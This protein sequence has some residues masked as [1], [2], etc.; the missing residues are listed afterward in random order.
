MSQASPIE[1]YQLVKEGYLRYFD[2]AFWLRYPQLREERRR[3]LEAD[4]AVFRDLLVEPVMPYDAGPPLQEVCQ[5]V[6]LPQSVADRLGWMLFGKDGSFPVR[7]HQARALRISLEQDPSLPRHAIVTSGTGSGKTESFLLPIFARL[8]REARQWERPREIHRWWD[9]EHEGTPWKPCRRLNDSARPAALRAIVLYPTNAL[10]EDQISRLRRA[11]ESTSEAPGRPLLFFGRYT[12]ATIGSGARPEHSR[13]DR[14]F[15]AARMLR[16]MEEERDGI[17]ARDVEVLS[18]FP[19]PRLGEML[20][21]WDMI[22]TP[23]DILVTN[24]SMLNVVLMREREDRMFHTT[25]TWLEADTNNALTLVVDELHTYRGT[26]GSEVALLI[27]KLLRRLG[28][29]LDAP[30]LRI[31]GTSA[32]LEG[33]SGCKFIH[34]FFGVPAESFEIVKGSSRPVPTP[35]RLP[36]APFVEIAQAERQ[37]VPDLVRRALTGYDLTGALAAACASGSGAKATP[38]TRIDER[39][40]DERSN[41]DDRALEGLLKA[42]A[43]V[44]PEIHGISFRAHMFCRMIRG[45][46]ACSSPDCTEIEEPY[47]FPERTVGKLYSVPRTRCGCGSR[48]LE[49]LYCYQC[50]EPSLGGFASQPEGG[51]NQWYLS[52]GPSGRSRR[53]QD[54][55]FR[56]PYREYMWYWPGTCPESQPWTHRPSEGERPV[57]FSFASAEYDPRQGLLTLSRRG[58]ATM[59]AV[60]GVPGNDHVRIPALPE[61]CPRCSSEGYNRDPAIFFRGTVR[62]P[63]RAHTT[64]TGVVTQSLV[65]RLIDGLGPDVPSSRI[66]VFTDSRDDA[67]SVAAGLEFNHFRDLIRQLMR[68]EARPTA[69]P[70]ALLDAAARGENIHAEIRE[71]LERLKQEHPDVWVAYR[72]Q[73]RG[74]A[75][76]E[77]LRRIRSFEGRYGGGVA[78]VSWSVLLHRLEKH[79]VRL[80]VNPAGPAPSRACWQ[81]EPWWR[82]YDPPSGEWDPLDPAL[83]QQGRNDRQRHLSAAVANSIF[84]RA[85]RDLESI[86]LGILASAHYQHLPQ[87]LPQAQAEQL[88]SS[89]IRLLGLSELYVGSERQPPQRMPTRLRTYVQ[90]VAEAHGAASAELEREVDECLHA[91]GLVNER[92]QLLLDRAGALFIIKMATAHIEVLRCR[93][94][95]RIH[96]HPSAGVCTNPTCNSRRLQPIRDD[97][98][99]DDY[100]AWLSTKAARRLRVE[101]LTGQTKPLAEQRRRQRYFKGAFLDAP[102]E[103]ALTHALDVLSVTTTMEVGVDIGSLQSVVLGNMP[104]QRFNYQQRVGRA[105]RSGQRF[106]YALTLCRDRTHDDFYFNHPHRITSDPPPPPYVDLE[107]MPII[108]RVAASESLRL[109]FAT[110]LPGQR[111]AHTKDSTHGAFGMTTDWQ[112]TY[113]Q[114][115]ADWL[116]ASAEV[117]QIVPDLTVGT[118]LNDEDRASLAAWLRQDLVHAIDRAAHD[119]NY[120]HVELSQTLANAG[121][122]PMF[123]FPSRVRAVYGKPPRNLRGD[124][125]A[126][127]SDRSLE[128]AISSFAPGSEVL[129]DKQLHLCV[130]FAAWQYQGDRPIPIDPLGLPLTVARCHVCDST[131]TVESEAE[132]ECQVCRTVVKPFNL[133]QPLGFRTDYIPADFDDHAER[134]PLLPPPQLAAG[135]PESNRYDLGGLEVVALNDAN[136]YTINDNDR[137]QFEMYPGPGGTLIVPDPRLYIGVRGPAQ[138]DMPPRA[139]GAIGAVKKTDAL[140]LLVRSH[141]V[142]GTDGIVVT[143]ADVLPAGL[144]AL[145]SFAEMLRVAAAAELDVSPQELQLGLQPV[146]GAEGTTRRIFLADALEN[147]AGYARHLGQAEALKGVLDRVLGEIRET[148]FEAPRH[149]SA[150]DS[151][152]PDCLRSY[153]NLLLH[154]YLDWRLAL[155]LAEV[156][157]GRP[158]TASRWFDRAKAMV[159]AFYAAFDD[160]ELERHNVAGLE[161]VRSQATG[162]VAI[163]GHPLWRSAA[164]H[165]VD[166]QRASAD[167]SRKRWPN[168]RVAFMDLFKLQKDPDGIYTWLRPLA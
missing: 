83:Q 1:L 104:P 9:R 167:A 12:G 102:S 99:F 138:P 109:A 156:A 118:G 73:A 39:L 77:D 97:A 125:E 49:L 91:S 124:E 41:G 26:Q 115:V 5:Q 15:E 61:R 147:G 7:D 161:V 22:L 117:D 76:S 40:F 74:A 154:P 133:Y 35:V 4:G 66:I 160:G 80:G 17:N 88:I 90:A 11:T 112:K 128:M 45:L 33:E 85:G 107:R 50:G 34:Q 93:D 37:A 86:G 53:E 105:G 121:L 25:R 146:P 13:D 75:D 113:R 136:V 155:D 21:R 27:R 62:T 135:A 82:L 92:W 114:P 71:V 70:G 30:Q 44:A 32:S 47:R 8:L 20:T 164:D 55:I 56:R 68:E 46:W 28:L 101:E 119:P 81:R 111:P 79:F 87:S 57:T 59:L 134:G 120:R 42:L 19:D 108:R 58:D 10:V 31:I 63:I 162:R 29:S 100:Y 14:V 130:G 96:L 18:Q 72:M 89:A 144:Y 150:C 69:A 145:W 48:V 36:R 65:D 158:L 163:F 106:S 157:A 94:C 140:T 152:C 131:R 168:D 51:D 24:Y 127:V 141:Q 43:T 6:G 84:D 67:A 139:I 54:L 64:G 148:T 3:L 143:N 122:L 151:S 16:E 103:S 38:L 123:G 126:K 78:E 129:R 165:W 116:R 60:A 110:L 52:A 2:T 23:P 95:A 137:Q 153:D 142:P 166:A 149:A 159:D 98:D 132:V